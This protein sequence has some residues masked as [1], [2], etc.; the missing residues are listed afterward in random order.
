MVRSVSLL[1]LCTFAKRFILSVSGVSDSA[2]FLYSCC[3]L[4]GCTLGGAVSWIVLLFSCR[5]DIPREL[6][7]A[8]FG[9]Q[10][11]ITLRISASASCQ[12]LRSKIFG[13][14]REGKRKRKTNTSAE[15]LGHTPLPLSCCLYYSFSL[16][17]GGNARARPKVQRSKGPKTKD[18]SPKTKEEIRNCSFCCC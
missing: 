14:P 9:G 1:V 13:M 5:A 2:R 12:A 6:G 10:I 18:Q 16:P 4:V 7:Q 15:V 11:L 8:Q 3:S 17:R